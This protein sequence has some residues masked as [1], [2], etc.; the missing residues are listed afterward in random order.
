MIVFQGVIS[1]L[2]S[3]ETGIPVKSISWP[4]AIITVSPSITDSAPSLNFGLNRLAF[5]SYTDTHSTVSSPEILP[6]IFNILFG[7]RL[8]HNTIPSSLASSTSQSWAG[9]RS[10][11]DRSSVSRQTS[12]TSRAPNLSA[13]FA[14]SMATFP[15]P[16]TMTLFP[17]RTFLPSL[18]SFKNG[19]P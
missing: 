1:I 2:F 14:Q 3:P 11:D 18:I 9:I 13:L 5:P 12:L 4:M 8:V 16:I 17:I 6:S 19:I 15:P 7:P 10:F